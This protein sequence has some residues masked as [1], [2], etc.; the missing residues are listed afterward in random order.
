MRQSAR[1]ASRQAAVAAQAPRRSHPDA[2]SQRLNGAETLLERPARYKEPAPH[3]LIRGIG[4]TCLTSLEGEVTAR[5]F[6]ELIERMITVDR[7][8]T[9]AQLEQMIEQRKRM[10][11]TLTPEELAQLQKQREEQVS[12]LTPGQLAGLN[13]QRQQLLPDDFP[14][15]GAG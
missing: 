14:E 2:A 13:Q 5:Q 10:T 3:G 6:V 7:K 4:K 12:K 11:A 9:R 8:L 1:D 15:A